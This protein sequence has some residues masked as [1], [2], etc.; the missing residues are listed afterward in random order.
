MVNKQ[1][2]WMQD[3]IKKSNQVELLQLITTKDQTSIYFPKNTSPELQDLILGMIRCKKDQRLSWEEVF[4]HPLLKKDTTEFEKSESTSDLFPL[5]SFDFS[6]IPESEGSLS[7]VISR[8]VFERHVILM[9]FNVIKKIQYFMNCVNPHLYMRINYLMSKKML[10][11]YQVL[12]ELLVRKMNVFNF[13]QSDWVVF[14][15]IEDLQGGGKSLSRHYKELLENKTLIVNEDSVAQET[16]KNF[17]LSLLKYVSRNADFKAK[18]PKFMEIVNEDFK[19]NENF[20]KNY[21]ET[22]KELLKSLKDKLNL[23]D[24]SSSF[25]KNLV[26]LIDELWLLTD[27]ANFFRL[28]EHEYVDLKRFYE[29]RRQSDIA[30]ILDRIKEAYNHFNI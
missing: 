27:P 12:K 20:E 6:I 8:V 7:H 29:L 2:P 9:I 15:L 3:K 14:S 13:K 22:I 11:S 1:L 30:D 26:Y 24:G 17:E 21:N 16:Y 4:E 28:D 23:L 10:M 5:Q 19:P 25:E 18:F